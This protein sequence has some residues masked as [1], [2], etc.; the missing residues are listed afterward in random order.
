MTT[1][2]R[3]CRP[4]ARGAGSRGRPDDNA[5]VGVS[6]RAL[7]EGAETKGAM[8]DLGLT[9]ESVREAITEN[10]ALTNRLRDLWHL[11]KEWLHF[12]ITLCF[13]AYLVARREQRRY[14]RRLRAA[15]S[16][17][18]FARQRDA[19]YT[20][21]ET[22]MLEWINHALRHEWRAVIGSYVD[23]I[24]TESLEETL[25]TSET[26]TAGV[27][28]GATVEELTFG[29]VP[30]DLK[31]YCSRYNP[32]EDYL[33]FEFDLTWQTVSSLI[34]LRAGVKPSPYLPRMSVPVSVTDLSITGRLLVGFRLANRSPGVSGVDVSFDNKPEI[35]VAIKPAGFAVS[36]LP[37]VHEWVSAKI[38]EV[39]ATSYVEPKR[40][41]YDFENAYLRSLDGAIAAVSGPGGALVVDVAGAQRLPATNKE[42]RTSNPY[43]ELTY[44]GVTRRTATR[45]NTTAPEWNV[46][47]VFP[48]PSPDNLH[49]SRSSGGVE[50]DG[51]GFGS[52]VGGV[53]NDGG[54]SDAAPRMPGD[55]R[56]LPLRVR[57]MDW[58][59]LG[60]PRCIGE[61][62]YAVDVRRLRRDASDVGKMKAGKRKS[63]AGGP[64][65][66]REVSLPLRRTKGGFVKLLLGAAGPTRGQSQSPA[67]HAASKPV[68]RRACTDG[69]LARQAIVR[70]ASG[71]GR[72]LTRQDSLTP[73]ELERRNRD[74]PEKYV[75]DDEEPIDDWSP[76]DSPLTTPTST[77]ATPRTPTPGVDGEGENEDDGPEGGLHMAQTAAHILQM[78]KIQRSRREDALRH[79]ETLDAMRHKIVAAKEDLRME[80]DRREF[81]LRRALVE[82]A[83]FT[84]HTKR[85]PG[86]TPGTYRIWF[87]S[88]L[89]RIMWSSGRAPGRASKLHQFVPVALIKECVVGSG[90]FTLGAEPE[91]Q[92]TRAE[93]KELWRLGMKSKSPTTLT[94]S[95]AA[96]A[97]AMMTKK[98]GTHDPLRCF[99]IV[100]WKPEHVQGGP[101]DN[102]MASGAASLGLATIDL[103]LPQEGNGR[104]VREWCEAIYAAAREHG[105]GKNDDDDDDEQDEQ[106]D[107]SGGD[108]KY[109]EAQK[110]ASAGDVLR[111]TPPKSASR[112]TQSEELIQHAELER[113]ATHWGKVKGQHAKRGSMGI[114]LLDVDD[115]FE[116]LVAAAEKGGGSGRASPQTVMAPP[117]GSTP[118]ASG[119]SGTS[120]EQPPPQHRVQ[121]RSEIVPARSPS[122]R[123]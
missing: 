51:G 8:A 101:N 109:L 104:S 81:E 112:R 15:K 50:G 121:P 66:M 106:E 59:P 40:Y 61:A 11:A 98:I 45:I 29:V 108:G 99:S 1:N 35:H 80:R 107:A 25:R 42:S 46:R 2:W 43:C 68:G 18:S 73:K 79:R 12:I 32:T 120:A 77:I 75:E 82:G 117:D 20:S 54:P 33:H 95:A 70:Q 28:I 30:P 23:Q 76:R 22:G 55:G 92:V 111:A 57:V 3:G 5:T 16:A 123:L 96:S 9:L 17:M 56:T 118:G 31:M 10:L 63:D 88:K 103:E 26:N 122:D 47:V 90:A 53:A 93:A 60:E 36:D 91:G 34:V 14:A 7:I 100:L 67:T 13:V 83:V 87:N 110:D 49:P 78:A 115:S 86:F 114:P 65:G 39:F 21:V 71:E 69:G 74:W 97:R 116:D 64:L 85:S 52:P 102:V 58:S 37:G 119:G 48:L 44:G 19:T 84:C 41:T 4:L 27:T 38:A 105:G 89:K 62:S 6:A 72:G 24:A 113:D 94:M